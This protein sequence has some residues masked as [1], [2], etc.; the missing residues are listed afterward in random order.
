MWGSRRSPTVTY[1][2]VTV[3]IPGVSGTHGL[4]SVRSFAKFL[5]SNECGIFGGLVFVGV[6]RGLFP[7]RGGDGD[8]V[9]VVA[10]DSAVGSAVPPDDVHPAVSRQETATAA[11]R[12][13][14]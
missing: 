9:C 6:G 3:W 2:F 10:E 1:P 4:M 8:G 12:V 14:R 7:G 5:G 13:D 11:R